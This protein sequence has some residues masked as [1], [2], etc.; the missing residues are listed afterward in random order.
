MWKVVETKA[1]KIGMV[2]ARGRKKERRRRRKAREKET[3]ER[4]K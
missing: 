3:K 4:R 2:E 1:E